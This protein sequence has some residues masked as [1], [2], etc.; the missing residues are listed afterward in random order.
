[1]SLGQKHRFGIVLASFW[2]RLGTLPFREAQTLP[3]KGLHLKFKPGSKEVRMGLVPGTIQILR[4]STS[5]RF[6]IAKAWPF[7]ALT[8]KLLGFCNSHGRVWACRALGSRGICSQARSHHSMCLWGGC[9][10]RASC[11]SESRGKVGQL[12]SVCVSVGSLCH[13]REEVALFH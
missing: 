12:E 1:M 4:T 11:D 2:H 5:G 6:E 8:P 3:E 13:A 9:I 10:A 7:H